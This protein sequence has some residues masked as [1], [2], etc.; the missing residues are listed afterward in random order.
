V[1]CPPQC[2]VF[3]PFFGSGTT[4]LVA[5]ANACKFIGIESNPDYIEI[6][7]K[8]LS[9]DSMSGLRMVYEW[10]IGL[11]DC[12][13][14]ASET[15]CCRAVG[16]LAQVGTDRSLGTDERRTRRRGRTKTVA[17]ARR[18]DFTSPHIAGLGALLYSFKSPYRV[19][20]SRINDDRSM[21]NTRMKLFKTRL[22]LV[23]AFLALVGIALGLHQLIR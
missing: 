7:R 13:R 16:I 2:T 10:E 1:G 22:W 23:V 12:L 4:G 9:A 18:L 14:T 21:N 11:N 3:D 8:R 19:F 17:I 20:F 5:Q 6:A 15:E